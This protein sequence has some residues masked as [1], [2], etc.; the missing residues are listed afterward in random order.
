MCFDVPPKFHEVLKSCVSLLQDVSTTDLHEIIADQ[1]GCAVISLIVRIFYNNRIISG[2]SDIVGNL[3]LHI[4]DYDENEL[5]KMKVI[6]YNMSGDKAG[7]YFMQAVL[8]CCDITTYI[9][10]VQNAVS[11]NAIDYIKDN[12]GNFV[13]QSILKRLSSELESNDK[14]N[15]SDNDK[16]LAAV[17]KLLVK[18]ML[19]YEQFSDILQRR[20]G[21]ILWYLHVIRMYKT[22]KYGDRIGDLITSVWTSNGS[23]LLLDSLN[24]KLTKKE[25][26]NKAAASNEEQQQVPYERDT[27]QILISKI[28]G[29]LMRLKGTN[30][31]N[32]IVDAVCQLPLTTVR[33]IAT[34]GNLSKAILDVFFTVANSTR[35]SQFLENMMSCIT[36]LAV[37]YVGQHALRRAYEGANINDKERMVQAIVAKK[38]VI[39]FTKEGK[40]TMRNFYIDLY[41]K[42]KEDWK[43]LLRKQGKAVELLKEVTNFSSPMVKKDVPATT[44][45]GAVDKKRKRKRNRVK[46]THQKFDDDEDEDGDDDGNDNNDDNEDNEDNEDGGHSDVKEEKVVPKPSKSVIQVKES[47]KKQK[48]VPSNSNGQNSSKKVEKEMK[49]DVKK[50]KALK[51]NKLMSI[52]KLSEIISNK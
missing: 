21:V 17:A 4:L 16:G 38:D 11:N 40:N 24:S 30:V 36:E 6:V 43:N 47:N 52:E 8:E 23:V 20:G 31:S 46:A 19:D 9:S 13:I 18:E 51:S 49:I 15:R 2:G 5:S 42:S 10:I 33:H 29:G 39:G 22:S 37:H 48:H 41:M 35:Y 32:T 44:T 27:V 3:I 45:D 1:S 25:I 50:I 14:N 26:Q 34:S 7:S 28:I 12:F